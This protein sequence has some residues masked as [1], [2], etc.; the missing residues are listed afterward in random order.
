M[1]TLLKEIE[2]WLP[3]IFS[4]ELV[5]KCYIHRLKN[6]LRNYTLHKI[7][8]LDYRQSGHNKQNVLTGGP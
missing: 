4:A 3:Q 1:P 7:S 8:V 5:S 2:H 6:K